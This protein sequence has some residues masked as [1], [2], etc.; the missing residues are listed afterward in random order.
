MN[1]R[2][3]AIACATLALCFILT[4]VTYAAEGETAGAKMKRFWQRLF[5]YPANVTKESAD[6]VVQTGRKGTAVVTDEVKRV[7]QVTSGDVEKTGELV[8]EPV[9]GTAEMTGE[10]VKDTASIPVEAAKETEGELQ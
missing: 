9:M 10:A 3:V 2:V 1:K 4:S 6:V 7:G 8:T 5:S